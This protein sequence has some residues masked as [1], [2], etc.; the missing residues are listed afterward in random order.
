VDTNMRYLCDLKMIHQGV[1]MPYLELL[2]CTGMP[3]C[4]GWYGNVADVS[5]QQNSTNIYR[6]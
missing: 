2:W 4:I 1:V 6:Q 3:L 5:Y